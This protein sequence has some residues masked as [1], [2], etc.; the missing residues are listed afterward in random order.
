MMLFRLSAAR[1]N[2]H[3][4]HYDRDY[5]MNE[6]GYPGLVVHGPLT[7]LLLAELARSLEGAPPRRLQF[8]GVAP[9]FD[10]APFHLVARRGDGGAME[11]EAIGPD[12]AVAN[13]ATLDFHGG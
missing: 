9:L 5:A 4:I 3:R 12:G 13:R 7:A 8:R 2:S 10:T 6:E 1:Y 11:L